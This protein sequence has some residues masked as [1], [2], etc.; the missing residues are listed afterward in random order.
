MIET[1]VINKLS[2]NNIIEKESKSASSDQNNDQQEQ[3]LNNSPIDFF[4]QS[5]TNKITSKPDEEPKNEEA[6]EC[7]LNISSEIENVVNSIANKITNDQTKEKSPKSNEEEEMTE[8][9]STDIS[10]GQLES[11]F[12]EQSRKIIST[13]N[14]S[15]NSIET[16]KPHSISENEISEPR[17]VVRRQFEKS[18]ASVQFESTDDS[19]F[20]TMINSPRVEIELK[21]KTETFDED[22]MNNNG[23]ETERQNDDVPTIPISLYTDEELL[24]E[25][26]KLIKTKSLPPY[27]MHDDLIKFAKKQSLQKLM[28]EE[29][30]KAAKIDEAI[31]QL[32]QSLHQETVT[33][34]I[35]YQM[36]SLKQYLEE[37]KNQKVMIE[38]NHKQRIDQFKQ[39]E[40]QMIEDKQRQHQEEIKDFEYIWSS[41][42][43]MKTFNKPSPKLFQIRR[44]Q[45][46]MAMSHDFKNAL[47]M[48]KLGD[49]L[50]KEE[51]KKATKKAYQ[52]ISTK[53]VSLLS[54]QEKEMKC[55]IEYG[56]RRLSRLQNERDNELKANET[57]I[58]ALENRIK[59]PILM[60]RPRIQVSS[61]SISKSEQLQIPGILSSRT[62]S[63]LV[64]YKLNC[65][66]KTR[67]DVKMGDVRR[68]TKKL[69]AKA[70]KDETSL[71]SSSFS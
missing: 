33:T 62:R 14:S 4:S 10:T 7:S 57:H 39:K 53:F 60:K 69:T 67:L 48:K 71:F 36:S 12:K 41:E 49:D 8:I 11:I 35:S 24:S 19:I 42:E 23:N 34:D 6:F 37:A 56:E 17:T 43:K 58:K 16:A 68:I 21:E 2:I 15:E 18:D 65:D 45:K 64:N 28:A 38:Q 59:S 63:Q 22:A 70:K 54:K 50:Q 1:E 20:A 61:H 25:L 66:E 47:Y 46:T 29:Y 51:S 32:Q 40:Q 26:N 13:E 52:T 55:M 30:E 44:Q 9:A 3:K 27:E 5:I 31:V